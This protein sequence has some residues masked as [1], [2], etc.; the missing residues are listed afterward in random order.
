M[1]PFREDFA[2]AGGAGDVAAPQGLSYLVEL[3]RVIG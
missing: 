2:V 1:E 3:E